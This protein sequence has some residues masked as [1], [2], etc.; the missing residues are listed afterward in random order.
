[1]PATQEAEIGGPWF[2]ASLGKSMTPYWKK[3]KTETKRKEGRKGGREGKR[4]GGR[5]KK[6]KKKRKKNWVS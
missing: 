3:K 2:K 5:E 1:M 6:K 4:E